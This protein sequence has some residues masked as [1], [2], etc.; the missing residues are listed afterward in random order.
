MGDLVDIHFQEGKPRRDL[1]DADFFE[2]GENGDGIDGGND[3]GENQELQQLRPSRH[4][5]RPQL[6]QDRGKKEGKNCI[7]VYII[8]LTSPHLLASS[9]PPTDT[10]TKGRG[11]ETV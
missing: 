11:G 2:D 10:E 9:T 4:R 7:K 6:T 8:Y 3:G 5:Q 1:I